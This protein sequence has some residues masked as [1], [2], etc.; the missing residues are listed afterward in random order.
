MLLGLITHRR[1]KNEEDQGR[2]PNNRWK[3]LRIQNTLNMTSGLLKPRRLWAFRDLVL[4][5]VLH[6]GLVCSRHRVG[7]SVLSMQRQGVP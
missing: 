3:V 4:S 7:F 1:E 6:A 5:S 2:E